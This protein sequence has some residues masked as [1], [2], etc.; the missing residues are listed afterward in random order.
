MATTT[1]G[2]GWMPKA[3]N[4]TEFPFGYPYEGRGQNRV[5]T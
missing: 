1:R 5:E 4:R 2:Y 3:Q